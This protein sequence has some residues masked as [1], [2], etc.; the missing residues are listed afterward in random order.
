MDKELADAL[1]SMT[2]D[3]T[4]KLSNLMADLKKMRQTYPE[5]AKERL[6]EL[7]TH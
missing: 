3:W 6:N 1:A 7:V 2:S 5:V 4:I